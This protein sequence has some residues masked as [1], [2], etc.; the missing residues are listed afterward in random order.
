MSKG[1]DLAVISYV[2]FVSPHPRFLYDSFAYPGTLPTA[3]YGMIGSSGFSNNGISGAKYYGLSIQSTNLNC[4]G[5]CSTPCISKSNCSL[6]NGTITGKDCI[7]CPNNTRYNDVKK[8]CITIVTCG[9]NE[10]LGAAGACQCLS[11]FIKLGDICVSRCGIN[12][13]WNGTACVCIKAHANITNVCRPCPA[14]SIPNADR[15]TCQCQGSSVF[16][17]NTLRCISFFQCQ[18]NASGVIEGGIYKCKCNTDFYLNVGKCIY[19]PF[20]GL[21][22][23][24]SLSCYCP[25]T[26]QNWNGKTCITC[27]SGQVFNSV[28]KACEC[29]SPRILVNG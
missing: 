18:E 15:T 20:P 7:V 10:E 26:A 4:Q 19:C 24:T 28:T 13:E 21:W 1:I 25:N 14:T 3:D 17:E 5:L 8:A 22:N 9:V 12:Q 16:D 29:V 27:G 2:I 11:G 23:T 6:A